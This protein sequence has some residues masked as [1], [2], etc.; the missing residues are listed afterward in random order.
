MNTTETY[1]VTLSYTR[2]DETVVRIFRTAVTIGVDEPF[3]EVSDRAY[4][5]LSETDPAVDVI[6][7]EKIDER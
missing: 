6:V 1:Q 2:E 5:L 3:T 7:D 4:D